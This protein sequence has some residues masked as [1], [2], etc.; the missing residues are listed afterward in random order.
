MKDVD[1]RR[2]Q[3]F[4]AAVSRIGDRIERGEK[5]RPA[6]WTRPRKERRL[7]EKWSVL[8]LPRGLPRAA[9]LARP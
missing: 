9:R 8:S 1:R 6:R 5:M 4:A 7:Q 2:R 3:S